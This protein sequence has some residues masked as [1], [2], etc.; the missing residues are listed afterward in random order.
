MKNRSGGSVLIYVLVTAIIV[1]VVAAGL[2]QIIL[3]RYSAVQRMADGVKGRKMAEADYNQILA[4]WNATG[5]VCSSGGG[6][7]C[8]GPAGTCA[9][10]CTLGAET[11]T[12]ALDSDGNCRMTVTTP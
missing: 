9:C 12:A 10:S 7:L 2:T 4:I 6:F 11:V 3:S 1:S 5:K 8:T